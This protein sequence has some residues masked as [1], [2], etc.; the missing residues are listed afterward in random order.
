VELFYYSVKTFFIELVP[1]IFL[2]AGEN[3]KRVVEVVPCIFFMAG[4]NSKRVGGKY[5]MMEAH[6]RTFY[7]YNSLYTKVHTYT[8]ITN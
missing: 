4:E 7:S 6:P 5:G 8:K 3:S 2:L 1:C